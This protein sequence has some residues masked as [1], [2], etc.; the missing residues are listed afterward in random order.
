MEQ[1]K[2]E[3][4]YD[5]D[6]YN[7]SDTVNL[8]SN[9]IDVN[10]KSTVFDSNLIKLNKKLKKSLLLLILTKAVENTIGERNKAKSD[11]EK[12]IN[13]LNNSISYYKSK[14]TELNRRT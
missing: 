3:Y 12:E 2:Y 5:N 9:F 14:L 8:S 4:E 7:D 6:N 1:K 11:L 13:D 10:Y